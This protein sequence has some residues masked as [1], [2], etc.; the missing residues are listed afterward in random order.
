MADEKEFKS[1][2]FLLYTDD[3]DFFKD[4]DDDEAGKLIKA[5]FRYFNRGEVPELPKLVKMPFNVIKKNIDRDSRKYIDDLKGKSDRRKEQWR[6]RK[7]KERLAEEYMQ[8]H[9][10]A[11][12]SIETKTKSKTKAEAEAQAKAEA[13]SK[14]VIGFE[15]PPSEDRRTSQPDIEYPNGMRTEYK[16]DTSW[17]E[18]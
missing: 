16:D 2:A 13:K 11:Y 10:D 8:M 1:K 17:L 18:D 12:T 15:G 14:K 7:E 6:Q 4:L 3:E 9:A 5:L